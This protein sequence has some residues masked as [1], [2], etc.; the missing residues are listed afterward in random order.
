M[1]KVTRGA[2]EVITGAAPSVV[3]GVASGGSVP[4]VAG[5]AAIQSAGAP[6]SAALNVG[7]SLIPAP[8]IAPVL[9]RLRG[10]RGGSL[11]ASMAP[12]TGRRVITGPASEQAAIRAQY[13]LPELEDVTSISAAPSISARSPGS[14][15]SARGPAV[16]SAAFE[17]GADPLLVTQ[18]ERTPLLEVIGAFRKAGLLTGAKTHLRNMGGNSIFQISEELARIPAAVLDSVMSLKTGRRTITGPSFSSMGRSVAKA[19]TDGIAEARQ[20]IRNGLTDEALA[21]LEIPHEINSGSKMIDRYVN[22]VFRTLGAEDAVFKKYAATR[23]IEDRARAMAINEA[24]EGLI[25]RGQIGARVREITSDPPAALQ[26]EAMV[27]AEIATFNEANRLA[28]G[29]SRFKEALPEPGKFAVDL[30][31]PFVKT[32]SN[33]LWRMLEYS[34]VGVGAGSFRAA[35]AVAKKAF[36]DAEQRAFAQTFGRGAVGTGLLALGARL[37]NEGLMTGLIEDDPARRA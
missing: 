5:V 12:D 11:T 32:P 30:V 1:G 19:A 10:G 8:T 20:I 34:P 3:T 36:T 27:D 35:K 22:T 13:G 2:A 21:K 7:L 25:N 26:A 17:V 31:M 15:V 28:T 29:V 33:I 18:A 23:A 14:S 4:A 6:E 24:R 9:R 16:E 37:Y